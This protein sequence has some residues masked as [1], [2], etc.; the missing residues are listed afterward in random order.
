MP[1][2]VVIVDD[3]AII[4]SLFEK[5]FSDTC[6]LFAAEEGQAALKLI[7]DEK[8]D[9]VFLDIDMPGISGLEVLRQ[10]KEAGLAPIVW[11]LT[12]KVQLEVITEAMNLGA[13]GYLTKPFDVVKIREIL[14]SVLTPGVEKPSARPWVV[15]RKGKQDP[16]K[17]DP[18]KP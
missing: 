6:S 2:K 15:K 13:A 3:D 8:P 7:K 14:N 9:L 17:S 4:R 16:G 12:G 10:L 11:M 5:F 18:E 1:H